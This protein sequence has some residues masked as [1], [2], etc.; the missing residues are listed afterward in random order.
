[1]QRP[2]YLHIYS[3]KFIK[4][5]PSTTL[6]QAP[7]EARHELH[8]SKTKGQAAMSGRKQH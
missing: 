5:C 3:V 4:A 8:C 2:A 7:E 6:G 1:M